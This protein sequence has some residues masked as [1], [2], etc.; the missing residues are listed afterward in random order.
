[1]SHTTGGSV[2]VAAAAIG[3]GDGCGGGGGTAGHGSH[4]S[5]LLELKGLC[6]PLFVIIKHVKICKFIPFDANQ[7]SKLQW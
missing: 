5:P 4:Y 2:G 1:M 3:G 6:R 7:D